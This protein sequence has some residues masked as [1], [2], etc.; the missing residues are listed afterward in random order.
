MGGDQLPVDAVP[1]Q[2]LDVLISPT[3]FGPKECQ[4][5]DVPA[6]SAGCP[7]CGPGRRPGSFGPACR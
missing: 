4:V 6:A 1:E 2:C 3:R 7:A 5:L